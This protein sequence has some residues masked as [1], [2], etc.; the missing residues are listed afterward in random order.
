MPTPS[1]VPPPPSHSCPPVIATVAAARAAAPPLVAVVV[2]PAIVAAAAAA[3]PPLVPVVLAPAA[4]A[5]AAARP[6]PVP[7]GRAAGRG[8]IGSWRGTREMLTQSRNSLCDCWEARACFPPALPPC[9]R[10]GS[11]P[12]PAAVAAAAAG[13]AAANLSLV[14]ALLLLC[15]LHRARQQRRQAVRAGSR[16]ERQGQPGHVTRRR[17]TVVHPSM[18]ASTG[19]WPGTH[20]GQAAQSDAVS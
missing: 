15:E 3:A 18:Q 9:S 11:P 6:P 2:P 14:P 19:A 7:A 16:A 4:A 20:T 1:S 17:R 5:A 13:A 8:R 12:V 10:P